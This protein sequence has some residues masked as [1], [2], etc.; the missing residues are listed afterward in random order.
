MIVVDHQDGIGVGA[1]DLLAQREHG[2]A[3]LLHVT[4]VILVLRGPR[5]QLK[6]RMRRGDRPNHRHHHLPVIEDIG[7]RPGVRDNSNALC[8]MLFR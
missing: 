1:L 7:P 8:A 5:E 3:T 4:L 6:V 2:V